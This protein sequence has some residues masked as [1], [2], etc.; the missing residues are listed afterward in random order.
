MWD[1]PSIGQSFFCRGLCYYHVGGNAATAMLRLKAC[2]NLD[3]LSI[4]AGTHD[5]HNTELWLTSA[6]V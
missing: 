2:R 5:V 3:V 4:A 6:Y 1:S